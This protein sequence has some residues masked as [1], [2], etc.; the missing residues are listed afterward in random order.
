MMIALMIHNRT[1]TYVALLTYTALL[2]AFQTV[3][4]NAFYVTASTYTE[5]T[6]DM[7][8]LMPINADEC[9]LMCCRMECP[10]CELECRCM[11]TYELTR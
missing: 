8:T 1:I 2:Y 11:F 9:P 6:A 4:T 7:R 10:M 3:E 5:T